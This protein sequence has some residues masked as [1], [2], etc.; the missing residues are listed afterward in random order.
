MRENRP[1]KLRVRIG[2][3]SFQRLTSLTVGSGC[4]SWIQDKQRLTSE[5]IRHCFMLLHDSL[6]FV[7]YLV[8]EKL[9][10]KKIKE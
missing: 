10:L 5:Y 1:K 4:I 9:K 7:P 8:F 2:A 3:L 6:I